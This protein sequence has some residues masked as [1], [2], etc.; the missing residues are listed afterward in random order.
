MCSDYHRYHTHGP[1]ILE[2][3]TSLG[4][5]K[6]APRSGKRNVVDGVAHRRRRRTPLTVSV[7]PYGG[8]SGVSVGS[9][10]SVKSFGETNH[11]EVRLLPNKSTVLAG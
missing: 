9:T 4:S 1:R 8:G 11:G 7:T 2:D 10:C 3:A 5:E 6:T